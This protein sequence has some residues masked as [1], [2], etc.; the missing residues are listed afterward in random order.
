M[1]WLRNRPLAHKLALG[2]GLCLA[3]TLAMALTS[4]VLLGR[5]ETSAKT[6]VRDGVTAARQLATIEGDLREYRLTQFRYAALEG[7][8][9]KAELARQLD[10]QKTALEGALNDF[11]KGL[12]DEED[13]RDFA[14]L[15]T[16]W[17][18]Y[19]SQTADLSQAGTSARLA[20][21]Q[22]Q[23][24]F[25][26]AGKGLRQMAERGAQRGLR[27]VAE[28]HDAN[29]S[30]RASTLGLLA[31]SLAIGLGVAMTLGRMLTGV[32]IRLRDG[33]HSIER[34]CLTDLGEAVQAMADG[35]LTRRP[36]AVTQPI[37]YVAEDELGQVVAAF[38]GMLRRTQGTVIAFSKSQE[39]LGGMVRQVSHSADSVQET[40]NMLATSTQQSGQAASE[41]A[42][43]SEKLA[44]RASEAANTVQ[45]LTD[46]IGDVAGG[47]HR[48]ERLLSEATEKLS[49]AVGS[50]A[51]VTGSAQDMARVAEQGSDAV[52]RTVAAMGRVGHQVEDSA[53]RV[54]ALDEMGRQI[55]AIVTTIESIAGQTNL[56][57]LNAA[58]EAARAGEHG[59]GFAVVAD[60]V[61]KLAEQASAST[62]QIAV[63]IEDVRGSVAGAVQAIEATSAETR[64]G[65]TQSSEAGQALAEI[66][67]AAQAVLAQ[68]SQVA[69]VAEG[70]SGSMT[71]VREVSASNSA[72][73][74]KMES[75]A[76]SVAL[77]VADVASVSEET[78]AG[79]EEL[80]A[81]VQEVSIAAERLNAMSG[82]LQDLTGRFAIDTAAEP[83]HGHLRLAA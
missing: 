27:A 82:T 16:A 17:R 65:V 40:S 37:D 51:K 83:S 3:F 69:Q 49:E 15:S 33:M 29:A 1:Q 58:I 7:A 57:A 79:A 23:T 13:R 45:R 35:N 28:S 2:F 32:V 36:Q 6:L 73:T 5:V 77:T 30:A 81:T 12:A 18:D 56:L 47:S 42:S 64:Q 70:V 55:G 11:E 24:S 66:V 54:R 9:E 48:Q 19:A 52:E 62:K 53:T 20:S 38:N 68:A 59:R 75:L 39:S 26:T 31:L 43:A 76:N 46:A 80:S 72:T 14:A 22:P 41:I 71:T 8:D 50:L 60:E 21:P 44:A 74:V 63:L 78:A 67:R 61:R 34:N 4:L 10:T 25:E